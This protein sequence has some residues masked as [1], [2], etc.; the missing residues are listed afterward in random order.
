MIGTLP[1]MP[2]PTWILRDAALSLK[3]P[4]FIAAYLAVFLTVPAFADSLLDKTKKSVPKQVQPAKSTKLDEKTIIAGLKEALEVGT[5]KS[6]ERVSQKD[7]Y[8][9]NPEIKIPMP[10]DLKKVEKTLRDAG[11]GKKV[12]D[13]ILSMNRAAEKAAPQARDIFVKAIKEMTVQDARK[14]LYDGKDDEATRYFEGKT[15][16]PLYELFFPVVKDSLGKAGATKLYKELITKYNS[17]PLVEKKTYDL[18]KYVTDKA[19]DGLFL[20]VAKEEAKIRKDP[21]AR[22]TELLRKVFG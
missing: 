2:R 21:G 10:K 19:L 15:R 6:V 9:G 1:G 5:K 7:G 18:D 12:D 3:F 11:L 14:I 20:M 17:L 8:Y 4:L 22:I 13:F 16:G